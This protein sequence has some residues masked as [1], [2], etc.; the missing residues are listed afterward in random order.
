M[1][2][3]ATP[4]PLEVKDERDKG[5]ERRRFDEDAQGSKERDRQATSSGQGKIHRLQIPFEENFEEGGI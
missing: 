3:G 2:R 4:C 1:D 5:N